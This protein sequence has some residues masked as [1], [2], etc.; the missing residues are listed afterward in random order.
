[1]GL[2]KK[3]SPGKWDFQAQSKK[4][5]CGHG[6]DVCQTDHRQSGLI[7]NFCFQQSLM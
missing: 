5:G 1:M 7:P 4:D 2:H 6:G 3:G